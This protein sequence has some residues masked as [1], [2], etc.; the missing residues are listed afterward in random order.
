MEDAIVRPRML[1]VLLVS[2][3][4]V[5]VLFAILAGDASAQ[6]VRFSGR[7]L[8]AHV[9]TCGN[10]V[11]QSSLHSSIGQA[12]TSSS[13]CAGPVRYNGSSWE[14]PYGWGCHP[15]EVIYEYPNIAAFSAIYN[16]NSHAFGPYTLVGYG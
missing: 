1:R 9:W 16:P 15:F 13:V 10:C 2:F 11:E 7:S 6:E 5:A 3:A 12:E 14:A 4:L 8:P